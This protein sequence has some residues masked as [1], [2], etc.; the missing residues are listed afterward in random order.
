VI[1]IEEFEVCSVWD[2][3]GIEDMDDVELWV[4]SA[5]AGVG[6][7]VPNSRRVDEKSRDGSRLVD[8]YYEGRNNF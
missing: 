2:L 1:V 5:G 3:A 7:G 6:A 4:G 8:V